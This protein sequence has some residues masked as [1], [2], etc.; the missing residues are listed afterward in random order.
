MGLLGST[1]IEGLT[2]SRWCAVHGISAPHSTAGTTGV[3]DDGIMI[4]F[5]GNRQIAVLIEATAMTTH[6]L[7]GQID[8]L[9][10]P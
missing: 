5:I 8:P 1:K 3:H 9:F 2:L 6:D 10:N 4:A 7:G